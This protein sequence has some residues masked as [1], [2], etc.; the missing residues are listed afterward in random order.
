MDC[1]PRSTTQSLQRTSAPSLERRGD[2]LV[3][4]QPLLLPLC[5]LTRPVPQPS[6]PLPP[7]P[8]PRLLMEFVSSAEEEGAT[9]WAVTGAGTCHGHR[10]I[11]PFPR[12]RKDGG[13]T[14]SCLL[15]WSGSRPDTLNPP[16]ETP[17]TTRGSTQT[18]QRAVRPLAVGRKQL[19]SSFGFCF[20]I[21]SPQDSD[22][23][24]ARKFPC[25]PRKERSLRPRGPGTAHRSAHT[26]QIPTST[27]P[28]VCFL[29]H[30]PPLAQDPAPGHHRAFPD[31]LVYP[32]STHLNFF[33]DST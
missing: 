11:L 8:P 27:L 12:R 24:D 6:A 22:L 17:G 33:Q 16:V 20:P 13:E 3:T 29:P 9:A 32:D 31:H 28:F 25:K 15:S 18:A 21:T 1:L 19:T 23:P 10:Y 26:Q 4:G 14:G 2:V 30:R 5:S 7:L